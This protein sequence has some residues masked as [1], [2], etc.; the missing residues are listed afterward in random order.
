MST[1]PLFSS[2]WAFTNSAMDY[3]LFALFGLLAFL[4]IY[5]QREKPNY[6]GYSPRLA[7]I[8][9][10]MYFTGG[11]ILSILTGVLP[12]LISQPIATAEQV[13]SL[14]WWFFTFLCAGVIYFAYFYLWVKG[15]LTH[16]RELRLPQVLVF[17]LFWGLGEGQVIL[18]AWAVTEKFIGNV[19]LTALVTFLIVGTFK[20]LWQSQYWD[21]YVAPEH[22][23]PEWNLKKVL[24]GHI[25]N[26]I[27]TLS[28]L[29]AFGNALIFLLLQ[30]AGLMYMTYRMRFPAFSDR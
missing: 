12:T 28:Y 17:G 25:P 30:T 4:A 3:F 20:G 27:C 8:R 7:W 1:Q 10:G 2:F 15:T 22:N 29:A 24:L 13:S 9:G 21:I 23:I 14:Y 26:L 5:L 11:F 19:W 6:A 16:G 18:S